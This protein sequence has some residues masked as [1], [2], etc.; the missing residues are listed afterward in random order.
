MGWDREVGKARKCSESRILLQET[1][2]EQ[3]R[4]GRVREQGSEGEAFQG[5]MW[6]R[7]AGKSKN[8]DMRR[9]E[10]EMT[11]EQPAGRSLSSPLSLF[12]TQFSLL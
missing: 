12:G 2:S 1:E 3:R 10:L 7:L 11:E 9:K 6:A 5:E 4:K 8:A